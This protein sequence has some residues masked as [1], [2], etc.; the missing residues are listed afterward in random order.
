LIFDRSSRTSAGYG[1]IPAWIGDTRAD[2]K[3]DFSVV[4]WAR[5][6]DAWHRLLIASKIGVLNSAKDAPASKEF[7]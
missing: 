2:A 3:Q 6:A 5:T 1:T 4:F 7:S